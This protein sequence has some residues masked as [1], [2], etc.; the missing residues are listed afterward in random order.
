MV[1]TIA[2]PVP[3]DNPEKTPQSVVKLRAA[4][5][6]D[7][8]SC[9]PSDSPKPEELYQHTSDPKERQRI[10]TKVVVAYRPMVAGQARRMAPPRHWEEAEQAGMVGLLVALDRYD[11]PTPDRG[12]KSFWGFA[13]LYVRDEIQQWMDRGVRWEKTKLSK[14]RQQ[15]RAA[16]GDAPAQVQPFDETSHAPPE[17]LSTEE[18]AA[19]AESLR[20]HAEFAKAIPVDSRGPVSTYLVERITA[21][22]GGR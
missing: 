18:L 9:S 16:R 12:A 14:A 2:K 15:A 10:K 3:H 22:L 6:I 5:S 17:L 13:V 8:Q 7:R 21:L 1:T 20:R 4:P 11:D 19:Q